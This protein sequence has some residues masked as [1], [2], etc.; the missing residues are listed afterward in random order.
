[1]KRLS[2]SLSA[3]NACSSS[4]TAYGVYAGGRPSWCSC[5]LSELVCCA[6]LGLDFGL[7]LC[8][9]ELL[10]LELALALDELLEIG[11]CSKLELAFSFERLWVLCV[12]ES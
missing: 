6:G 9:E 4:P 8:C 2:I 5:L 11:V 12:L 10:A 1:M 7:L 3:A